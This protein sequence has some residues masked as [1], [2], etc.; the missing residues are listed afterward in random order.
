MIVDDF[1]RI[2]TPVDISR[3]RNQSLQVESLKRFMIA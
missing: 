2:I 1:V 3:Q